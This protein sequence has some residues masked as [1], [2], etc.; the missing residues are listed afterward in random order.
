[1]FWCGSRLCRYFMTTKRCLLT[2]ACC[3]HTSLVSIRTK[4]CVIC[5]HFVSYNLCVFTNSRVERRRGRVQLRVDAHYP[6]DGQMWGSARQEAQKGFCQSQG[7][8]HQP[9]AW[10]LLLTACAVRSRLLCVIECRR[11]W[12]FQCWSI[13]ML[14]DMI[15][16]GQVWQERRDWDRRLQARPRRHSVDPRVL[17]FE[18]S[19]RLTGNCCCFD[20]DYDFDGG[21][22]LMI[23]CGAWWWFSAHIT[24]LKRWRLTLIGTSHRGARPMDVW[25]YWMSRSPKLRWENSDFAIKSICT[26]Y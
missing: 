24:C 17:W 1:M 25:W 20:V 18:R 3:K 22:K 23:V 13:F 10:G 26:W 4:N 11:D 6:T 2:C 5:L 19:V 9:N 16:V 15:G 14:F 7:R 8:R 12:S 21:I